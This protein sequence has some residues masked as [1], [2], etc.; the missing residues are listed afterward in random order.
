ITVEAADFAIDLFDA[1]GNTFIYSPI[2]LPRQGSAVRL[3]LPVV[4]RDLGKDPGI[5]PGDVII[6]NDPYACT[7]HIVD[8][9]AVKPIYYKGE[10][11]LW[12]GVGIHKVDMGGMSPGISIRAT[13]AYQEGMIIPPVK[14]IEQG[15]LRKEIVNL[16][17]ANVRARH[18]QE[19][20]LRGQIA[21]VQSLDRR[22]QEVI[23]WC[24]LETFKA[25]MADLQDISERVVRR[26]LATVPD[27]VYEFTD[28]LDHDGQTPEIHTFKCRVEVEGDSARI[29]FTGTDPQSP[30]AAN[31][32]IAC[33]DGAV[34]AGILTM[35]A[36][37]LPPNEGCFKPFQITTP[38]ASMVYTKHP[39][40]CGAGATESGFRAQ[41]VLLGALIKAFAAGSEELRRDAVSAEWGGSFVWVEPSG[42][43]RDGREYA[44]L[45]LDLN[46]MGGG[47]R[48]TGDGLG[49]SAMHTTVG[50]QIQ[51][52][53][54]IERDL[55]I[56]YLKRSYRV[57]C[58]GAGRNRGGPGIEM[59]L[60]PHDTDRVHFE[61]FHSRRYPPSWG[62]FGG[63]PGA[64][65]WV[66]IKRATRLAEQLREQVPSFTEVEGEEEV[67]PQK[68]F[69]YAHPGD[70]MLF[71]SPGGG[72]YGDPLERD[73]ARVREDVA[74]E[75][76]SAESA[77]RLYGVVLSSATGEVDRTATEAL[78]ARMR[79]ERLSRA[80]S[81]ADGGADAGTV[82]A[83]GAGLD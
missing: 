7:L 37:D 5:F 64:A 24:G 44:T 1:A 80:R 40:P 13:N 58:P 79:L 67:L 33:T 77:R 81:G 51:N 21:A 10:L 23:G 18:S 62:A 26:R 22:L 35:L 75:Y 12:I 8:L 73:P 82:A 52:V 38:E 76:V 39:A 6:T 4:L 28:Y 43:G 57:D 27:G 3:A 16:Y 47:G 69:F 34:H 50:A 15:R 9:Q 71:T 70:V 42:T 49:C 19:L 78:R 36:H 30:G 29:D 54:T 32:S 31:G 55:P 14:I 72:G 59:F 60:T 46:G 61:V 53:E 74:D 45:L 2:G 66:K 41:T 17:M 25:I 56:L 11:V 48:V 63:G 68:T 65:A 83:P 20:D